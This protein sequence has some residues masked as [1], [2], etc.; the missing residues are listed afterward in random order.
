MNYECLKDSVPKKLGVFLGKDKRSGDFV[1]GN[2]KGK[3][4]KVSGLVYYIWTLSDGSRSVS[5]IAN[6]LAEEL[7][8]DEE[9]ILSSLVEVFEELRKLSLVSM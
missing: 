5:Q 8:F 2:N 9:E 4:A 6:Q 1:L 3:I 7:G